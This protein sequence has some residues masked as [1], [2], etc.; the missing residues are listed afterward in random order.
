M[1]SAS[2]IVLASPSSQERI[3]GIARYA[4]AAGWNL[5]L[6]S[7]LSHCPEDWR[8]D[9]ALVTLKAGSAVL[10]FAR[11]LKRRG[12]PVVNLSS[13][14]LRNGIPA[15]VGDNREIGSAAAHH[16]FDRSFRHLAWFSANWD[17][18][19]RERYRAFADEWA[20]LA[21]ALDTPAQLVW[22]TSSTAANRNKWSEM[23]RWLASEIARLPKPLGIFAYSDYDASRV[24]GICRE[25]GIDVP[26]EV[27]ILGVD[28]NPI[29]CEN[30][31]IALSSV[32]HDLERVGYEG[33]ALLDRLM[34]GEAAPESPVLIPP[35]GVTTRQSTDTAAVS[36]PILRRA[37][38]IIDRD[39]AKPL[40]AA[41][42]ADRIGIARVKLDR[43][44]AAEF[45]TSVGAKILNIRLSAARRLLLGSD[46]TL[47][48]IATQSGFCNAGYLANTFRR[49]TGLTP[50]EFRRQH[51]ANVPLVINRTS[52]GRTRMTEQKR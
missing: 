39:Y 17:T 1:K 27:S 36:D 21:P 8:G 31:Q 18:I 52:R 26:R 19:Q 11:Q 15:V 37:V 25:H 4:K 24:L 12:I 45:G 14:H 33:A 40:G 28:N 20:R 35:R 6:E 46:L 16:F 44:F 32:N 22:R 7:Q 47:L 5:T 50:G 2:V 34:Q 49:E 43:L 51:L 23:S 38:E 42:I 30:Q 48:E 13:A 9:G 41:Q 10:G 29:I 3:R